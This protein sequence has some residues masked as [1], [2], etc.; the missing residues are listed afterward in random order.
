[1]SHA[2]FF[3]PWN[4]NAFISDN[5]ISNEVSICL[6]NRFIVIFHR[7]LNLSNESLLAVSFGQDHTNLKIISTCVWLSYWFTVIRMSAGVTFL[8]NVNF[9]FVF[10]VQQHIFQFNKLH[11]KNR[12]NI[13]VFCIFFFSMLSFLHVPWLVL[14]E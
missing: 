12:A 5:R 11:N 1:M 10:L 6:F 3:S 4:V 13:C 7:D 2:S 8:K 9:F 14:H